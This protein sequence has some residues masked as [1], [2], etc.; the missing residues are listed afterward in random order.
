MLFQTLF[1]SSVDEVNLKD[2]NKTGTALNHNK[3]QLSRPYE[4]SWDGFIT[5]IIEKSA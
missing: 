2:M 1:S 5:A 4:Y 3:T